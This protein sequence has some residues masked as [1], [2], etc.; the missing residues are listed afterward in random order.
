LGLPALFAALR[1]LHVAKY[2]NSI[3]DTDLPSELAFSV[4]VVLPQELTKFVRSSVSDKIQAQKNSR[5]EAEADSLTAAKGKLE[6]VVLSRAAHELFT[7]AIEKQDLEPINLPVMPGPAA[8]ADPQKALLRISDFKLVLN[9]RARGRITPKLATFISDTFGVTNVADTDAIKL[10]EQIDRDLRDRQAALFGFASAQI[11]LMGAKQ[12]AF[13]GREFAAG[14]LPNL[15]V[16]IASATERFPLNAVTSLLSGTSPFSSGDIRPSGMADLKVVNQQLQKYQLGEIAYIE[17]VLSGEE[18]ERVHNRLER[19]EQQIITE[20]EESAST[21]RDLQTTERFEL[22]QELD[23]MQKES[24]TNE[25]GVTVSASYGAVSIS[26]NAKTQ[27]TSSAETAIKNARAAIRK[28]TFRA[29]SKGCKKECAVSRQLHL[30]QRPRKRTSI[31]FPLL[32]L[33]SLAFI[34]M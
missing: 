15:A 30:P 32:A 10:S 23:A 31:D 11:S 33:R 22:S 9:A 34:A 19:T 2:V 24:R 6:A 5:A 7:D 1:L 20:T 14:L 17:N 25:A 18:R 28:R 12:L 29:R 4:D 3:G 21:E 16:A 8:G 26:A 27:S 13:L